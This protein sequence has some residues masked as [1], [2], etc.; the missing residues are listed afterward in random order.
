MVSAKAVQSPRSLSIIPRAA[1]LTLVAVVTLAAPAG[2]RQLPRPVINARADRAAMGAYVAYLRALLV[3]MPSATLA[4]QSFAA[5]TVASCRDALTPI[6]D[7]TSV[8]S[9]W[10]QP[11]TDVGSEL[12]ADAA[13]QFSNTMATALTTLQTTLSGLH[14]GTAAPAATV[15]RFLAA[16]GSL[17]TLAPSNL[18][19]DV[20]AIAAQ[21]GTQ[22]PSTPPATQSFLT[23]YQSV[24]SSANTQLTAFVKLL[25]SFETPADRRL[26]NRV[27]A[28]ARRVASA[29]DQ[30]VQGGI[31]GL[32]QALGIAPRRR[33]VAGAAG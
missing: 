5:A 2:A 23:Q 20:L 16:Q 26:A 30:V 1:L 6:A 9:A 14:W 13:L 31:A 3:A 15:R 22:T 18:C 28:L 11:L 24:S 10:T 32:K 21:S 25:D 8:S 19:G 29:S 33:P 27:N 12:A 7:Q 4:E 17:S